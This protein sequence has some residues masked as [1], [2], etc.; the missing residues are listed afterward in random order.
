MF[1]TRHG[2]VRRKSSRSP[3]ST[4]KA[5]SDALRQKLGTSLTL[6]CSSPACGRPVFAR[7]NP[8]LYLLVVSITAQTMRKLSHD[9]GRDPMGEAFPT[10]LLWYLLC[11]LISL[12]ASSFLENASRPAWEPAI[13]KPM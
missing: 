2:K 6:T 8:R 13:S 11:H 12:L 1:T 4:A 5:S 10:L 3:I 7:K 9:S